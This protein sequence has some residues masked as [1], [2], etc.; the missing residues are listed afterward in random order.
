M[1][2][3]LV[4]GLLRDRHRSLFPVLVVFMGVLLTTAFYGLLIGVMG[5]V[6]EKMSVF[7]TGHVKIMSRAY[8]E[9]ASQM[10]NDLALL[11]LRE[12]MRMLK[13]EYPGLKWA[14]RIKFGGLLDIPDESGETRSQGPTMGIALDLFNPDSGERERLELEQSLVKGRLPR[15]P[16]EI[17]IGE[18][19]AEELGVAVGEMATLLGSTSKGSMSV[20]NFTLVG[21]IHFGIAV[22]DRRLMLADISDIQYTLDMEDGAGEILGFLPNMVWDPPTADRITEDFNRRYRNTDDEYA[23]EMITFR[24]QGGMG[25]IMDFMEIMM[26]AIAFFF[27]F[28]MSIV[29]WNTGLMSGL[30]RYG[31]M[32]V[33]L[34]MGEAKGHVYRSLIYEAMSIGIGGSIIG[35]AAGMGIC[36]Y[37][38]EVGFDMM[39]FMR[40]GGADLNVAM[41]NI[42]RAKVTAEGFF[43]GLIPGLFSTVLGTMISGIGI[44]RRQTSTLFKELET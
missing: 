21:T 31:E 24:D 11:D 15:S 25:V 10:P 7:E 28:F 35:T 12:L 14:P 5:D 8:A 6:Y 38:Q 44:F 39:Y 29:L 41:T 20:Q 42:I 22:M 23:P 33:R 19:F 16:G 26:L 4:K 3:F 9:I 34:A 36:Y 13:K 40:G 17:V 27:L 1:I 18:S 32:G 30:R 2:R 43:I 37:F